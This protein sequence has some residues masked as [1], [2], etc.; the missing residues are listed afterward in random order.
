MALSILGTS[1]AENYAKTAIFGATFGDPV[2]P[3][4]GGCLTERDFNTIGAGA[5][6][7]FYEAPLAAKD[8][9]AAPAAYGTENAANS[10]ISIPLNNF[11][12][13]D[14][15]LWNEVIT[16]VPYAKGQ[17]ELNKLANKTARQNGRTEIACLITEGTAAS[18]TLAGTETEDQKYAIM[19]K[20]ITDAAVDMRAGGLTPRMALV[21]PKMYDYVVR[22]AGAALKSDEANRRLIGYEVGYYNGM[23]WVMTPLIGE[24]VATTDAYK[25]FDSTNSGTA[26]TVAETT[27]ASVPAIIIDGAYFV[28]LERITSFGL[29][30]GAPVFNGVLAAMDSMLGVKVLD[31]KAVRVVRP[32]S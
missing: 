12:N 27:I 17:A 10:A 24:G 19:Y 21:S 4:L 15:R 8:P 25:Y 29:K 32:N 16:S 2:N 18:Y 11:F 14:K 28:S 31:T 6:T 5:V 23:W 22:I 7:V 20:A 30:D 3:A 13:D 1:V 26:I 9:T